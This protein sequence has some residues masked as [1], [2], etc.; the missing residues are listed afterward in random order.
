MTKIESAKAFATRLFTTNAL[1]M[2]SLD[3]WDPADEIKARDRAVLKKALEAAMWEAEK[4][5]VSSQRGDGGGAKRTYLRLK[6]IANNPA[7]LDRLMK[8]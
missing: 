4:E 8:E 2:G 3:G 7:E 6:K 5:N 1:P